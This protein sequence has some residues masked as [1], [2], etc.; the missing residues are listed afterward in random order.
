MPAGRPSKKPR[1]AFA[2][3]I[4][5]LRTQAKLSQIEVA[6]QL[7]LAQQ[8]YAMW[9]R[10]DVAL[11]VAQ[12]EQL[13]GIFGVPVTA[14]FAPELTAAV[15]PR[16]PTGRARQTFDALAALPRNQQARVLNLVEPLVRVVQREQEQKN[17]KAARASAAR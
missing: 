8:S 9:E 15:K 13:A 16:G 7:G 12:L 5:T 10:R 6:A 1:S 17:A 4:H 11:S 3:R 14:F 2:A